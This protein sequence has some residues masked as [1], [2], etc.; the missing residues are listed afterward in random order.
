MVTRRIRQR[1]RSFLSSSTAN[2]S[3]SWQTESTTTR[4]C[5]RPSSNINLESRSMSWCLREETRR[6]RERQCRR[7]RSGTSTSRPSWPTGS[8]SGDG[9]PATTPNRVLR[10][11]FQGTKQS[12]VVIFEQND[13]TVS[14]GRRSSA[15]PSSTSYARWAARRRFVSSSSKAQARGLCAVRF[16]QQ[17][18]PTPKFESDCE[19][20]IR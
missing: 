5:T 20:S 3:V 13:R 6:H 19:R 17:R 16:M 9:S 18:R 10:T 1:F 15:A 4:R 2:S 11:C 14:N 7:R 12:L 8:H